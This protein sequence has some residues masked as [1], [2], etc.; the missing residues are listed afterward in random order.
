MDKRNTALN[1]PKEK[2][3]A[4]LSKHGKELGRLRFGTYDKAYFADG[5]I[6]KNSG[7]GCK[8][9]GKVKDGL[10]PLEFFQK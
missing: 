3:M 6:L 8:V 5:T 10:D 7:F 9:S 2:E 1:E 4:T